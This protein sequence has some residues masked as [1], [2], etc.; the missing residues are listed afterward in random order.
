MRSAGLKRSHNLRKSLVCRESL[1]P[2]R[3]SELLLGS[4]NHRELCSRL[5]AKQTLERHDWQVQEGHHLLERRKDIP[6]ELQA[7][8]VWKGGFDLIEQHGF[9]RTGRGDH[10]QLGDGITDGTGVEG[11]HRTTQ[12]GVRLAFKHGWFSHGWQVMLESDIFGQFDQ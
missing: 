3:S 10:K 9:A 7:N 12:K 4:D 5:E 11:S 1:S 6:F 2:L 8:R